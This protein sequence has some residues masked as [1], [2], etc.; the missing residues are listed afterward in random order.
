MVS[1]KKIKVA[2]AMLVLKL[3]YMASITLLLP[4]EWLIFDFDRD[5]NWDYLFIEMIPFSLATYFYCSRY[6]SNSDYSFISTLVFIMAF[7][8]ANSVLSLCGYNLV[9]YLLLNVYFIILFVVFSSLS[10]GEIREEKQSY[11]NSKRLFQNKRK[12]WI[13]RIVMFTLCGAMILYTYLYNGMNF[14][15]IFSSMYDTRAEYATHVADMEDS[16]FS[17]ILLLFNGAIYWLL[18][19][20]LYYS[21]A[22]KKRFDIL[23]SVFTFFCMYLL[24][25][26]KS[27]LM[28]IVVIVVLA[29][30]MNKKRQHLLCDFVIAG[31]V[32]L[33]VAV[34]GEYLIRKDSFVFSFVIDRM[35]YMPAYL[36]EKY[37]AFFSQ[38]TKFW[39]TR[40]AFLVEEILGRLFNTGY[41]RGAV[42]LISTSVFQGRVPSP[43]T[44]MFAE[45]YLQLGALGAFVFPLLIG[46]CANFLR[47]S[48][49]WYGYGATIIIFARLALSI[50]NTQLLTSGR[51]IGIIM[52]IMI[53]YVM[54]NFYSHR[55][56]GTER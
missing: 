54:K 56:V 38:N 30:L 44:G 19:I 11:F 32:C 49:Q 15:V 29:F 53:T 18:P 25:M 28:L 13:I 46:G 55:T 12:L 22:Y 34:L 45:A 6:R 36:T 7:I 17:Y 3:L 39:L 1:V 8:P 5:I 20:Y 41:S 51:V 27:T 16:L 50:L 23:L 31:F 37:Y 40:D 52:F 4:S 9:Y 42:H 35:F 14:S 21:I 26:Q 10:K 43:N 48:A 2:I 24:E 33:F 47:K